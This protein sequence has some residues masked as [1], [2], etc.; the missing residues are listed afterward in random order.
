MSEENVEIIRRAGE[1]WNE[2]GTAAFA[3]QFLTPDV[4][5]EDDPQWPDHQTARGKD[6]VIRRFED[7]FEAWGQEW[8]ATIERVVDSGDHRVVATFTLRTTGTTSGATQSYTWGYVFELQDGL[9]RRFR[10]YL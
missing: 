6:E 1:T 10:A 8:D 2:S 5:Y 3:D 7:F 4:L 9:I